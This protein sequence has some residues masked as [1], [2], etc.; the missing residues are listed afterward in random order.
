M[1]KGIQSLVLDSFIKA[2]NFYKG[3]TLTF[4]KKLSSF[5]WAVFS[6]VMQKSQPAKIWLQNED[7][8]PPLSRYVSAKLSPKLEKRD[9]QHF[10]AG[11]R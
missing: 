1:A 9:M 10:F 6:F 2:N 8:L 11:K 4:C 5:S 3:H 7:R